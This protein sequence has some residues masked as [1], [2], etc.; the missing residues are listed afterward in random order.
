MNKTSITFS[1][2]IGHETTAEITII[3]LARILPLIEMVEE[4]FFRRFPCFLGGYMLMWEVHPNWD[5]FFYA[6]VQVARYVNVPRALS[7]YNVADNRTKS[8]WE[9]LAGGQH[10]QISPTVYKDSCREYDSLEE[11]AEAA[12]SY[13]AKELC[14]K[15]KRFEKVFEGF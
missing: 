12:I 14:E 13:L 2:V 10:I 15:K 3:A 6:N 8:A 7:A 9:C 11:L 1:S 5:D 4:M